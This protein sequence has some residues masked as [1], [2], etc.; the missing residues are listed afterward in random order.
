VESLVFREAVRSHR[1]RRCLTQEELAEAT[2]LGL[3]TIR[4]LEAG[5]I[6]RPRPSTVRLLADAFRL[7]GGDRDQFHQLALLA[8]RQPVD[9]DG[10]APLGVPPRQ[11]PPDTADFTGR[12]AELAKL[13]RLLTGDRQPQTVAISAVSGIAGVGKTALAVHAAHRLAHRFP[14]GQLFLDLHGYTRGVPPLDPRDALDSL[15]RAV[16]TP[17][18]EI[19][20]GLDDRAALYRSQLAHRRVLV[21]LDN[22]A[23]EDQVAPLLPGTPGLAVLITSR[24]RLTGLDHAQPLALDTLPPADAA[25][26]FTQ[27]VGEP[28]LATEP[29]E[30]VAQTITLCDQLPLA[31]RIAAARLQSRPSWRLAQLVE[32]LRDHRHR[33]DELQAG[34][35]SVTAALDLS[36]QQLA[37]HEQRAYRLLGLHPGPD[38]DS[39]AAAALTSATPAQ[40]GRALDRLHEAHLL[41]EPAPGRYRFHDLVRAHASGL[42]VGSD[43]ERAAALTRLLDHYRHTAARAM[44]AGYPYERERRPSVP[45]ADLPAPD[46]SHAA[47]ALQWLGAE[48]PNLL[49]AARFAAETGWGDHAVDLSAILHRHLFLSG[50]YPEAQTLHQSALEIA[51][52]TGDRPGELAALVRL[53]QVH[54]MQGSYSAAADHYQQ[55]HDLARATG[56]PTAEVEALIGLGHTDDRQDRHAPALDHFTRAQKLAHATGQVAGELN[57]LI[58]LGSTHRM[59][60]SYQQA[61]HHYR[62]ALDLAGAS[63]NHN[64]E[65][66]ALNGLGQTHYL[67]GQPRPA[68]EHYRQ[69]LDLARTSGNRNGELYALNGLGQVCRA[70]GDHARAAAYYQRAL[71][72]AQ[73]IDDSNWQYECEQGLGR[74]RLA[75][76][77]P[78]VALDHHRRALELANRLQQPTDRARAHDG[79]ARAYQDLRRPQRARHHWRLALEILN[80]LG[81]DSTEDDDVTVHTIRA[82]LAEAA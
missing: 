25:G 80:G 67:R 9:R 79:L 63:G 59:L 12:E 66:N 51:R 72:I 19:P 46:L 54:R 64:G 68:A 7:D 45:P 75:A 35:R 5:R 71:E 57:S 11:L 17:G 49:A 15:L 14:D 50:R 76:G 24:R 2:G 44:N 43:P 1:L 77:R 32:R 23:T 37:G 52:T 60:G 36:Y 40:A 4:N 55:A 61:T 27:A 28:R 78:E 53:G 48:L 26:L 42:A 41:E 62:Q 22:A 82:H 34:S 13:I 30:L 69:A 3:R 58:G 8:P 70:Y 38:L 18:D 6:T 39:Y 33:L 21:V 29:P 74:L 10:P 81:T 56:N 65:L 20:A 16:G 73:L 47:S 31:I